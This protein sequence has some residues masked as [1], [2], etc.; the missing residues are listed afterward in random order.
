MSYHLL[1]L[2]VVAY[3]G[4]LFAG[5]DF[6]VAA[7]YSKQEYRIPMR[8][9]K[10]LWTAVYAPKDG[11]QRY[12]ILMTRTPYGV[13]PYGANAYPKRIGPSR[14]FAEDR[15]IFVY[16]DVRGRFMSE[17]EWRE[18]TPEKDVKRGPN[19]VDE[20]SDTHDTIEWLVRNVPN[21]NGKVGLLGTSYPGFYT[22]AGMID[23][24]PAL[25]AASPQAP[26]ADLYM[27]DDAFHNGA[28]FLIAN[29][30]FYTFF[31][32]QDNPEMPRKEKRFDYGTK[33]GYKFYLDMG[34]LINADEKHFRFKNPY[35]TDII[36]HP[37][38][39]EFWKARNILPHLKNIKPAVLVV[40]GW[41]DAEDL[42]GTLKTYRA[43]QNQSSGIDERLVMGP[44]VH[45]GWQ[46]GTG[47]K[48]GDIAFGSK[49][50]EFFRDE[51]E[52]PF[53]RH[54]LKGGDDLKLPRAYVFETGKNLWQK[55]EAWPPPGASPV[56]WY[57]RANRKL[58]E[59]VPDESSGF[60]EYVSDPGN[61]V[62]FFARP[63]LDM[64]QEYMDADQRFIEGRGDV[65]SYKSEVLDEDL[66]IA[67][68]I[69]A[70]LFVSTTGTDSDYVVKVI[71]V[72]PKGSGGPLSGYEELVR[73]EPFRGKFRNGFDHPEPFRPGEVEQIRFTM[74]DVYHCFLKGHRIMVQLESSWFPLVDRNPQI[75]TNIPT[76]KPSDFRKA[77]ERVYR[78]KDWASFIEVNMPPNA[79][80]QG[81]R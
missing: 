44:W 48:L 11:S 50:A 78:C 40:G 34:P 57:F 6:D 72:H 37:N 13:M 47:E 67:G 15:F 45:G 30:S 69:S 62:P 54:F 28:F 61:P 56:R 36:S 26:V 63:T 70:R 29:F 53:F 12:P 60:D 20:S 14:K 22:S 80:R 39:D 31:G 64:A 81:G 73:G 71:D 41:F 79:E 75:F 17:G 43:I 10:R 3:P 52:F 9:G 24:H 46:G 7:H 49:T 65:L 25:V 4:G 32:K 27:G 74:P 18:M 16:Q 19:D 55:E 42:S 59:D 21:N 23:A 68:P 5:Q 1:W 33:D 77:T 51:I 76:A 58:S 8:D 2:F 35:W 66:T 38:Y